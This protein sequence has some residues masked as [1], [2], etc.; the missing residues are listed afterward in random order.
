MDII[1]GLPLLTVER[2]ATDIV[3]SPEL[4]KPYKFITLYY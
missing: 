3:L 2:I 4:A 1:P